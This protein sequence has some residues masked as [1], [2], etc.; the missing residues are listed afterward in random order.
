MEIPQH[1]NTSRHPGRREAEEHDRDRIR[2]EKGPLCRQGA[3]GDDDRRKEAEAHQRGDG[4]AH[5]RRGVHAS[6]Q[7]RRVGFWRGPEGMG[8]AVL[9]ERLFGDIIGELGE[10]FSPDDALRLYCISTLRV[11]EPGIK[12]YELKD[13]YEESFL[14]ELHPAVA[15]SRNTVS[16]FEH[17]LGR[18]YPKVVAFMRGRAAKVG[19]GHHL[20]VDGTLKSDESK[21]NS[22]SGFSRKARTK[23]TRGISVVYAFDLERLE[24]VCGKCFPG[25]MLDVTAYRAF[26]GTIEWE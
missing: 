21:V 26:I 24:P 5:H 1:A 8:G 20:L 10:V 16:D 4:G 14:S 11:L 6:S 18:A 7:G 25:N 22:L 15:L 17:D 13:A 23:G 9:A 12:D 19:T 2:G 3:E